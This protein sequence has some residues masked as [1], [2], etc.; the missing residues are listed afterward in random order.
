MVSDAVST[1]SRARSSGLVTVRAD[2]AYY[3]HDI[4]TAAITVGAS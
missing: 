3:N 4:I 2:S 1:A